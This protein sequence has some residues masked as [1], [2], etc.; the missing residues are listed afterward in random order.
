M[1]RHFRKPVKIL[2]LQRM[3]QG[4]GEVRKK[5]P[6]IAASALSAAY[7]QGRV[8]SQAG[9]ISSVK[10]I[11]MLLSSFLQD[12][13]GDRSG[14]DLSDTFSDRFYKTAG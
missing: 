14:A 6:E 5:A 9:D 7:A 4:M 8:R 3:L 2:R 13:G 10:N 11:N 12:E 1:A